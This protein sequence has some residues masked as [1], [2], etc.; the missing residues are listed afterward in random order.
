MDAG[1]FDTLLKDLE[2]Q[3]G[4]KKKMAAPVDAVVDMNASFKKA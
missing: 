4:G 2:K 3:Y 1:A